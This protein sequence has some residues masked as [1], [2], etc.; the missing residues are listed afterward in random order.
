MIV[1]WFLLCFFLFLVIPSLAF[2]QKDFLLQGIL[3]KQSS[4]ER[5]GGAIITN[6]QKQITVMSND[7][8]TF[9]LLVSIGDSITISK[10][11]YYNQSVVINSNLPLVVHMRDFIKLN[12]VNIV[13]QTKLQEL[14]SFQ[15]DYRKNGSFYAGRPPILSFLTSPLTG[16]Y[17]LFGR[18]PGQSRRFNRFVDT[19]SKEVEVDRRFNR[20]FLKDITKLSDGDLD[21]FIQSFRPSYEQVSG[22]ND[23]EL[24]NYVKKALERFNKG[25]IPPPLPKLY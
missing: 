7:L 13:G 23:Y 12:E 25:D 9:Q 5:I 6:T 10:A 24:I 21:K 20:Y 14:K 2:A 4:S 3:F 11:Q 22:W 8:G 1:R 19:E 16:I 17:E 18:T 15:D